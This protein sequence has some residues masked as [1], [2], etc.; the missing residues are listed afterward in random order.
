MRVR[1]I[2]GHTSADGGDPG[3]PQRGRGCVPNQMKRGRRLFLTPLGLRVQ[4]LAATL[5]EER[6][7]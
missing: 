3:T 4:G 5:P 2:V 6:A 7:A 1:L